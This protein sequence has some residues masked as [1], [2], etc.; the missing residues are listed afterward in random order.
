MWLMS[1]AENNIGNYVADILYHQVWLGIQ[2]RFK[3][4]LNLLSH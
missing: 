2:S 3:N 1:E 4:R